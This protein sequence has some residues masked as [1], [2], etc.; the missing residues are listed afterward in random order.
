MFLSKLLPSEGLYCVAVLLPSGK[1]KHHFHESLGTAQAMLDSLDRAGHTVYISQATFDQAKI[2]EAKAH[3]AALPRGLSLEDWKKQAKRERSQDNAA[4][5]RNFFLDIDCGE[6]WKLKS[7]QEGAVALREFVHETGLPAPAVVNS[8]NGLYAQWIL[9][10]NIPAMQ[11]RTVAR[12][13]KQV[14]KEYK[15]AL[16]DDASRT[17]DSAS[18]LRPPG[19][20]NKKPGKTAKPVVLL[21]DAAPIP[22][23]T[24]VRALGIAAR[25]K[26]IS[27]TALQ[28]PKPVTDVNAEFFN[29]SEILSKAELVAE[30]CA[31]VRFMRDT[32]G[33]MSEPLWYACIGVLLFCENGD[34]TIHE[35][36]NGHPGYSPA[37]TEGKITQWRT[38][39]MGP[40]TCANIGS[41]NEQA[42]IGCPHN[43]KIKSPIVL[44]RP[45]PEK[46]EVPV[47]QCDA[48]DGFRR[49]E[50]GLFA[51][52]DGR[53]IRF[54]DQDLYP[55]KLAY[56]AS[57]GY[58]VMTVTHKLPYE[59]EMSFTVR[60][61]IVQDPK[62]LLTALSDNH[63]KVLGQKEKKLMT[64]YLESYAARL[65][66][67]RRMAEMLTQM[68]WATSRSGETMFILGKKI[69]RPDGSVEIANLAA[70]VPK[71]ANGF[72]TKGDVAKWTEMTQ[73]FGMPGMEPF[74]FAFLAGGF[75]APLMR[76]TGFE[77]AIVSM[78]GE[79]GSGK[80]LVS[81]G[82]QSVW[83]NNDDLMMMKGD[84][85]NALVSRLGVYGS[86]P[87]TI[88]EVTNIE[89]LTLSDLAYQITQGREKVRLTRSAKERDTLNKWN[90]LAVT[91]SNSSLVERLCGAKQD[92]SA[93]IN[94]IFEYQCYQHDKFREPLTKT[95]YW[96]IRDN[97]GHAGEKYAQWL[98]T[99]EKQIK[100][101]VD[102]ISDRIIKDAQ[103][104]SEER[105][106]AAT[107]A[108]AIY[109]GVVARQLGLIKFSV[110]DIYAWV[111]QRLY[112]MR[113]VK[114]DLKADAIS[115]LGEFLSQYAGNMVVVKEATD[116]IQVIEPP[117][118]SIVSRLAIDTGR[119]WLSRAVMKQWLA[120]KFGSYAQMR[121]ELMLKRILVAPNKRKTLSSGT[122]FGG[123]Q[124]L[125]WELDMRNPELY[126]AAQEIVDRADELSKA[127]LR[128][129]EKK[130][131]GEM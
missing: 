42:C 11:W 24:F 81:R 2:A 49:S 89:G 19:T 36:S 113:E 18:V 61:S 94:R 34:S 85:A 68:G 23:M 104:K 90:T 98:V 114:A 120:K 79:S 96:T 4:Y 74:A 108:V 31:Q 83:G 112:S 33:D 59:G 86:L 28:P 88:D 12:L 99:H 103:M 69:F 100:A 41:N 29:H 65:Q 22:F 6:K 37:Q 1:F 3:N 52:E 10:E 121:D 66:R 67:Q 95:V 116:K 43:G 54:Y 39:G 73:V 71:A 48:P 57:L 91:T 17:S 45:E 20:T 75:G 119:L 51:E 38:S 102:M 129:G 87:L 35:W 21:R 109:G 125:C 7:Q 50:G 111:V 55:S 16:G 118:G 53:W 117:R 72:H 27:Q 110:S 82:I 25:K 128:L 130:K 123:A 131:V 92:A 84:T 76:F 124:Q 93:E 5:L 115:I 14:V 9:E 26:H 105:F 70:G 80:T 127:P 40:A 44:G 56:D 126:G 63:V 8:G 13:L 62:M 106:W 15:P 78:W 46:I 122:M 101:G 77:G 97:Y 107:A 64:A 58:E 32:K 60:S 47:E 30:K